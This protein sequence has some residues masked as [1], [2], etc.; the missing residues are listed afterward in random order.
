MLVEGVSKL[1]VFW[2]WK[3][4]TSYQK[5]HGSRLLDLSYKVMRNLLQRLKGYTHRV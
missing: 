5:L 3:L 4:G 2:T 1:V